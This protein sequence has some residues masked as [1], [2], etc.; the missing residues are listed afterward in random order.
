MYLDG[1]LSLA[2][3]SSFVLYSRKFSGPIRAT[4]ELLS[5]LQ[6]SA[7]AAERVMDLLDE[8]PEPGDALSQSEPGK[9]SGGISFRHVDFGYDPVHPVLQDFSVEIPAGSMVAVV[10]PTGAGKTTLVSPPAAV[11]LSPGRQHHHRRPAPSAVYPGTACGGGWPLS[12]RTA[13]FAAGRLRTTSPT[14]FQAPPGPRSRRPPGPPAST[15]SS[16]PCRRV[17]TRP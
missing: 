11:L 13:G 10:G 1:T 12:C 4:A 7:A 17:M 8:P 15:P 16:P 2:A 5:D 3:L 6:A 9:L 14:A